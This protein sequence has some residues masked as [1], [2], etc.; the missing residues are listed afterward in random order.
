[1]SE[2]CLVLNV[3]APVSA[4]AEAAAPERDLLPVMFNIHGGGFVGGSAGTAWNLTRFSGSV[5]IAIQYRLGALGF[6]STAA[7]GE[8]L[9]NLGMADQVLALQWTQAN[10]RAFGGD[11]SRVLIFGCSAGG[12]SVA[13]HLVSTAA[14]GLYHA[15][16]IESP[17]GHQGWMGDAVRSNDDW[18]SADLNRENSDAL[19]AD[20]NCTSR[21]DLACLQAAELSVLYRA[22][23]QRRLAPALDG[24]VFPLGLIRQG[25]W[26]K[27]PTIIGGQSCESCADAE[28]RLGPP[29]ASVSTAELTDALVAEGFSGVNG[30]GVGATTL[31]NEWYA[32]R[33]ASEGN[34]RTLARILSD[35]GHA[36]SSAL[37]AEALATTAPAGTVWRYFFEY[38]LPSDP[39]PGATHGGDEAWLFRTTG[40]SA[41]EIALSEDMASWWANLAASGD[42]NLP[43][44]GGLLRKRVAAPKRPKWIA[45]SGAPPS[46]AA[47]P[48]DV[49]FLG[50]GHD[51]LPRLNAS[52]DTVR[53]ECAHWKAFLGW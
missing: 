42:P 2:D 38:T 53:A 40:T 37:H 43:S 46:G 51:P 4:L 49:M 15:A 16:G 22:S 23:L 19:A 30:S 13:G 48:H 11:P 24:E 31:V 21:T 41:D 12:A 14:T 35:S 9:P 26:N 20:I 33:I 39:L 32:A 52:I 18:M 29:T 47:P 25:L 5:V 8:A 6:F 10:A 50:L 36:C 17:G 27:V 7:E 28:A 3:F 45:Y 44:A 1:M 34:W